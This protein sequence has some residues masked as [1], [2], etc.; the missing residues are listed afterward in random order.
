M[1]RKDWQKLL[2]PLLKEA[3]DILLSYYHKPLARKKKERH[4]FVTEADLAS[5]KFLIERLLQLVPDVSFVA[6]ESGKVDGGG[7][8]CWVIDPLDGTTN[9]AYGLPY[10]CISVSLTHH[11][12]PIV[13]AIYQP[14]TQEFF[15]SQK[16]GGAFLDGKAI[17][18]SSPMRFDQTL[19]GIGLPYG[20]MK[21]KELVHAAESIAKN[22]YAIRYFGAIALDL[23]HVA[24][25]RMDGVFFTYLAWWDVAVGMV[26]VQEAG[27]MITDF[28]GR[29][30]NPNYTTCVAGGKMVHDRVMRLLEV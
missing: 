27:G 12:V 3:G 21:R 5:E 13:G 18:V 20:R 23:A 2:Q 15:Y 14:V 4:G 7:E 11:D 19:V 24:C 16:D 8:Y 25:G 26:L 9:F 1:Q 29:V 10:F 6:E 17:K 28:K 22:A 30:I